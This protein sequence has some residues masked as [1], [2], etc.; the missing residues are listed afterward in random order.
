MS[1][2]QDI[3]LSAFDDLQGNH[4]VGAYNV[5]A[6]QW[7]SRVKVARRYHSCGVR[8]I[9]KSSEVFRQFVFVARR[10][11]N[12]VVLLDEVSKDVRLI[13]APTGRHF[14]GHVAFDKHGQAWFTENDYQTG[15]AL[16]VCRTGRYLDQVIS[17]IDLEGIG[18]HEI[19]FLEDGETA[20]VGLGGIET[21]PDFPR[22]K[23][24]LDSMDSECLLVDTVNRRVISR[25]RPLDPQLSL[26]HLD[27]SDDQLVIAAQYQGPKYEQF[28]LV[29][30]KDGASK[31]VPLSAPET[32][33]RSM[34]QYI[35][36][37]QIHS[38]KS[39]VLVTCPRS[40]SVHLF[41]LKSYEWL[42]QY[43]MSDP[44]G[45]TLDNNGRFVISSGAGK[46]VCLS[47]KNGALALEREWLVSD[48]RWDN[49]MDRVVFS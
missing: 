33:W 15:R 37:V 5:S 1:S 48:T 42:A 46:I 39:E 3:V 16:L 49:H 24:N 6:Q 45:V 14:Y 44:G 13:Q 32:V 12:E 29:Y 38:S 40:N 4:Y 35:A 47:S 2:D 7:L 10:P 30:I 27:T 31:L 11:G 19:A 41:S 36:S 18:P 43:R 8:N 9:K 26:R 34:N 20:V 21:H 22:K 23:L 17:E 25:E 28:P